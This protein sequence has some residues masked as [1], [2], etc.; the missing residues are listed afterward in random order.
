M[1]SSSRSTF[2]GAA[3][4]AWLAVVLDV[5]KKLLGERLANKK[6]HYNGALWNV[7]FALKFHL[8]RVEACVNRYGKRLCSLSHRVG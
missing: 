7:S 3:W 8:R 5:E 4:E 1:Y 2:C 6:E